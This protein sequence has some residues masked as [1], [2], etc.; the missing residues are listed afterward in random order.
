MKNRYILLIALAAFTIVSCSGDDT[1][2]PPIKI[3]VTTAN[4]TATINENPTRGEVIGIV[5]G[6]TNQGSVTFSIT[7]QTPS[8]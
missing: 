3:T 6:S 4:F 1:T 7:E 8:K 2:D 5:A